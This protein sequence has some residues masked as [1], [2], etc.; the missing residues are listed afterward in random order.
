MFVLQ[1]G[2]K[3]K[4]GQEQVAESVFSG[5]FK[6][7]ISAQEGFRGVQFLRPTEGGEYILS[8]AFENQPLQQKW[9]G[10]ELHGRVWSQMETQFDSYTV[11]TYTG[12]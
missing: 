8:I 10:T 4:P 2:M 1:V 11:K 3:I 5:P 9:V 7:A 6:A 12:I